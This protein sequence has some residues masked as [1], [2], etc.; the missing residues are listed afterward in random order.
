MTAAVL[1]LRDVTMRF[2][3]L[4]AVNAVSFDLRQGEICGLIGPNGAGK[5]TLF[6]LVAG[7]LA[8]TSGSIRLGTREIGGL[9]SQHI[10]RLGLARAFQLVRL[11]SSMTV[12]ENV[13]VGAEGGRHLGPLLNLLHLGPVRNSRAEMLKTVARILSDIG[14]DHLAGVPVVNL[15]YGQQRLVATARALA[16]RP[17]IL[18]L[19]EPAAGLS[20]VEH[21]HLKGAILRARES[22][23]SVLLVEHN[24]PFVMTICDSV[25]VLNNGVKIADGTP[26]AVQGDKAVWEA[27]LGE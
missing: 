11:F 18:L 26:E 16:S 12:A 8:P 17:K 21:E 5:S 14:V 23:I 6:N 1:Q 22:G 24:V 2:G 27:Y 15:T 25:V 7:H 4:V 10:S 9:S 19:D 3:G 13:L 20:E